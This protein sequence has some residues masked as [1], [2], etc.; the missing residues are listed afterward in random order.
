MRKY[1][2]GAYY[3]LYSAHHRESDLWHA[4]VPGTA[5]I[6]LSIFLPRVGATTGTFSHARIKQA[7]DEDA[8]VARPRATTAEKL[9]LVVDVPRTPAL[10]ASPQP[11]P[12][13]VDLVRLLARKAA[14]DFVQGEADR[15]KGDFP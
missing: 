12:R 9:S 4:T 5:L 10:S 8:I 7:G 2:Y 1:F 11:D 3:R 15:C 14:W 13:L 6:S